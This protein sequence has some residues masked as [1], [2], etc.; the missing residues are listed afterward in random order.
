MPVSAFAGEFDGNAN[1]RGLNIMLTPFLHHIN[2]NNQGAMHSKCSIL[3]SGWMGSLML[4]IYLISPV[5]SAQTFLSA[6]QISA[7]GTHTCAIDSNDQLY[8]WGGSATFGEP[9]LGDGDTSNSTIP[10]LVSANDGFNNTNVSQVSAGFRH[11]CAIEAGTLYCWGN[12]V[13]GELGDGTTAGSSLPVKV[14]SSGGFLNQSVTDVVTG[15]G[16]FGHHTCAIEGGEVF[17]WGRFGFT[18]TD[19]NSLTPKK[20][21]NGSASGFTNSGVKKVAA[22]G[23]IACAIASDD[24]LYCW[25]GNTLPGSPSTGNLG[26]SAV[27]AVEQCPQNTGYACRPVLVDTGGGFPNTSVTDVNLGQQSGC[28]IDGGEVFCWGWNSKGQ[29]GDGTTTN[30]VG[31]VK[32]TASSGFANSSVTDI[33]MGG[34]NHAC[35][36]E[37]GK[38]YCWGDN[39]A[40]QL[41][42]GDNSASSQPIIVSSNGGFSNDG[43]V[44]Q[45]SGGGGAQDGFTNGHTCAIESGDV[46]C[47]GLNDFGQLASLETETTSPVQSLSTAPTYTIGG[48]VSG[49]EAGKSIVLLNNGSDAKTISSNGNFVFDTAIGSDLSYSYSVSVQTQPIGQMCSLENRFGSATANVTNIK[50]TCTTLAMSSPPPPAPSEPSEQ[51][52]VEPALPV[53]VD[54]VWALLLLAMGFFVAGGWAAHRVGGRV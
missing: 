35:A 11:T 15:Q 49:L 5:V 18:D 1:N 19:L 30:R 9:R 29:I 14:A 42:T 41:G 31:P 38:A 26:V 44:T 6:K 13:Q 34:R 2:S 47:W 43:S 8:C 12:N 7:G 3:V 54:N 25:G 21:L 48:E 10:K 53:P 17:C 23:N 51:S 40:G 33:S 39:T 52:P 16:N 28:A 46:F 32:V 50:V 4:A 36:L 37:G 45:I 22:G 27:P 20:I 24:K